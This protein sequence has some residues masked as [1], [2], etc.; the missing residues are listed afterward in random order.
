[1]LRR[2]EDTSRIREVIERFMNGFLKVFQSQAVT[3]YLHMLA[4][5]ATDIVHRVGRL[6]TFEQQ[7]EEKLNHAVT[8]TYFS[9]TN[10]HGSEKQIVQRRARVLKHVL[11]SL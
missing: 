3:P 8:S 2:E 6:G 11:A 7:A 1:M 10:Y 5:H 4:H 9:V